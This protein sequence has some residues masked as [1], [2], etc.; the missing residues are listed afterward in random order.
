MTDDG[1][2]KQL[3]K[4]EQRQLNEHLSAY[5]DRRSEEEPPSPAPTAPAGFAD[6]YRREW[7]QTR[8]RIVRLLTNQKRNAERLQ[9]W[10]TANQ[11]RQQLEDDQWIM[12][13]V[14]TAIEHDHHLRSEEAHRAQEDQATF[15]EIVTWIEQSDPQEAQF[16]LYEYDQ[17]VPGM[18][19][20]LAH[21]AGLEFNPPKRSYPPPSPHRSEPEQE[22]GL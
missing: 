7:E 15:Q 18:G 2:Y 14:E 20:K 9:N 17:D 3:S 4:E 1:I 13:R 16:L 6:F 21:A 10:S 11:I 19:T 5:F 8:E 12:R 22:P